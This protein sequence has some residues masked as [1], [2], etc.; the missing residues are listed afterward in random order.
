MLDLGPIKKRLGLTTMG[1]WVVGE[2]MLYGCMQAN[3]VGPGDHA[4]AFVLHTADHADA[5]F[6]AHASEDIETLVAEVERQHAET[7]R[8]RSW[9][10]W[11]CGANGPIHGL[12]PETFT[13][14]VLDGATPFV[15]P[16]IQDPQ[17]PQEGPTNA[18]I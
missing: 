8:L 3:P 17:R 14:H 6:I 1:P 11:L 4:V 16:P 13:R 9:V 10:G 2:N 5:N 18:G 15:S 12:I 7:E